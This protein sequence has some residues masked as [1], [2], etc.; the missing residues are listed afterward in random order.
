VPRVVIV[1]ATGTARPPLPSTGPI[2]TGR[3][4]LVSVDAMAVYRF[5][6]LGTAKPT[7]AERAEASWHL[8]DIVDPSQQFSVAAFQ[9]AARHVLE[10][11]ESRNHVP[12]LVAVPA[13]ITGGLGLA[14][15]PGRFP[16]VAAALEAEAERP[17]GSQSFSGACASS[18]LWSA[19]SRAG[20]RRRIVRA[21]EVTIGTGRPFSSYGPA[22]SA[23]R[24]RRPPSSGFSSNAASSIAGSLSASR[25]SSLG[26]CSRRCEP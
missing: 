3:Y 8:I 2:R 21:L 22:L 15:D 12:V 26:G 19:T 7:Q 17:G 25:T 23:T 24:R 4:E 13:F 18:T 14:R 6:D 20:N 10:G 11:I 16:D 1:G 9:A 5:L